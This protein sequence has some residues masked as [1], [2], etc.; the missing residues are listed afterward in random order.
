MKGN[1]DF[2]IRGSFACGIRNPGIFSRGFH[3]PGL[4]NPEYSSRDP[5]STN[6]L[7]CGIEVVPA[8]N[9]ESGAHNYE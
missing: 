4:R 1:P 5:E 3:N 9:P 7:E 6:D 8:N 2:E